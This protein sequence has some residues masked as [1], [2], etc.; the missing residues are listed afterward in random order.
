MTQRVREAQANR[1]AEELRSARAFASLADLAPILR[2]RELR[3][4]M[5]LTRLFGA[6]EHQSG[7]VSANELVENTKLSRSNVFLALKELEG[8]N[9]IAKRQGTAVESSGYILTFTRAT[10]IRGGPVVGLP[11]VS[12]QDQGGPT[13]GPPLDLFQDQGGPGPGPVAAENRPLVGAEARLDIDYDS[14]NPIIDRALRAKPGKSDPAEA[15]E[16]SRWIHGY[17]AKFGRQRDPHPPDPTILAQILAVASAGHVVRVVQ[18]LMAERQEPGSGYG[19][20]LTVVLQRIH[21]VKPSA[22]KARRAQLRLVHGQRTTQPEREL[23]LPRPPA[24]DIDEFVNPELFDDHP[25]PSADDWA[26]FEEIIHET[27]KRSGKLCD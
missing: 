13:P 27:L 21:G 1:T 23:P 17:Q 15:A 5:A 22:V 8:R 26:P 25:A 6:S 4:L 3:V 2:E 11:S 7:R 14:D 20:Y 24:P 10:S 16:V 12:Q 9:V 19:W 18:D